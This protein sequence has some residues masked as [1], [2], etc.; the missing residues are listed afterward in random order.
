MS[1][2]ARTTRTATRARIAPRVLVL[3]ITLAYIQSPI[4]RIIQ[5]PETYSLVQL[6]R[7][8]QIAF[9]WQERHL[10]AF[11]IAGTRYS[12]PHPE[13]SDYESTDIALSTLKLV[14]GSSFTYTYDFG[15]DWRHLIEVVHAQ[16]AV[17]ASEMIVGLLDGARA[18]PPED[19]GGPPGYERLLEALRDPKHPEHRELSEWLGLPFDSEAFDLFPLANALVL[20]D[21]WG[22]I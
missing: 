8:L 5:I 4:W 18:A 21:L 12:A 11:D 3:R 1:P 13:M 9:A 19:C 7:A 17:D 2:R 20:A 6:H 14:T 16:P 10:H 15:D 22:A